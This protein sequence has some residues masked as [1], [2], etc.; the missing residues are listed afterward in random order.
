MKKILILI[1]IFFQI[2]LSF[3]QDSLP[4]KGKATVY[5]TRANGLGALINFTYFDGN[6]AIGRFNGPKY[7]K[8]ECEAGKHLF[9]ARSENKSFV[10]AELEAGKIY[11]ID[12]IPRM[13]AFKAS[14]SLVP[15]DKSNYKLKHIQKLISK[16]DSESFSQ[17][18]LDALNS[19]M[20]SVS[21]TGMERYN[22][23]KEKG[24]TIPM[25]TQDMI[26]EKKDLIFVKKKK[27]K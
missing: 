25:L 8:Y 12:V 11:I 19:E 9:W 18:E 4:S 6:K 23:L 7:M 5:F 3:S 22:K 10:E 1:C 17:S 21:V 15:V 13:G 27:R 2:S 16:R 24:K 26:V 20:S 14:V